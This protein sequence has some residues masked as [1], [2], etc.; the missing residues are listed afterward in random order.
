[1][2]RNLRDRTPE[3]PR[4]FRFDEITM[5]LVSNEYFTAET[6]PIGELEPE[7][8]VA[9]RIYRGYPHLLA[10]LPDSGVLGTLAGLYPAAGTVDLATTEAAL[11]MY[12]QDAV[13]SAN[14][15]E[16]CLVHRG[17]CLPADRRS[18]IACCLDSTGRGIRY[19]AI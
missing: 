2:V 15:T 19:C 17:P 4:L 3:G 13:A 11:L 1:M 16:D 14:K 6:V 12:E 5:C 10:G 7:A 9:D 18:S 8:S